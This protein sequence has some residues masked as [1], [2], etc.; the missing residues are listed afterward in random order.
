MYKTLISSLLAIVLMILVGTNSIFAQSV[1][2][3]TPKSNATLVA[4]ASASGIEPEPL[5]MLLFGLAV[6]LGATTAKKKQSKAR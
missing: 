2:D 5:L 4:P 3:Q 1:E 6:F